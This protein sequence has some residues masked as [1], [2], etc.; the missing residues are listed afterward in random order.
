[1]ATSLCADGHSG[2]ECKESP[3]CVQRAP[4]TVCPL[5]DRWGW[6][7]VGM[8]SPR[9]LQLPSFPQLLRTKEPI[10]DLQFSPPAGIVSGTIP[11]VGIPKAGHLASV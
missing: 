3:G 6:A 9:A 10:G 8:D 4:D 1:M 2:Q 7:V 11:L 5:E